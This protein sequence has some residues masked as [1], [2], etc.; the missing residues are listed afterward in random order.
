MAER[1]IEVVVLQL[2][3]V[4]LALSAG[5]IMSDWPLRPTW[6]RHLLVEQ[7]QAGLAGRSGDR[8]RSRS[9]SAPISSASKRPSALYGETTASRA[10]ASWSSSNLLM[11]SDRANS[12]RTSQDEAA[13]LKNLART[14]KLV[15]SNARIVLVVKQAFDWSTSSQTERLLVSFVNW[16]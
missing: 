15:R 1:R 13:I 9:A 2:G 11:P 3:N 8:A 10:P 7:T 14:R 16:R 6:S 12:Q 4:D 5:K